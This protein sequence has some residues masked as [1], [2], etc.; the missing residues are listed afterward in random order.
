MSAVLT[1]GAT[2]IRESAEPTARRRS[3]KLVQP[4]QGNDTLSS[5]SIGMLQAS[6]LAVIRERTKGVEPALKTA[7]RIYDSVQDLRVRMRAYQ[8]IRKYGVWSY[9]VATVRGFGDRSARHANAPKQELE[10]SISKDLAELKKVV[11]RVIVPSLSGVR[12]L[13][14][15]RTFEKNAETPK[16]LLLI[17]VPTEKVGKILSFDALR[18]ATYARVQGSSLARSVESGDGRILLV[19]TINGRKEC[20][21]FAYRRPGK[22]DLFVDGKRH[23]SMWTDDAFKVVRAFSR[24]QDMSFKKQKRFA[25]Y[26]VY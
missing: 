8:H 19:R 18:V 21:E 1:V 6:D 24:G 11:E 13:F 12:E 7:S 5:R 9:V 15:G 3:P 14:R 2:C 10:Q 25:D 20:L 16:A 17:S 22:V 26:T 23:G 4:S